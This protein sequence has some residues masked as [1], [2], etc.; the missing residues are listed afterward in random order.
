MA[1]KSLLFEVTN[2]SVIE[3]L[4]SLIATYYVF[5]ISY[6][7]PVPAFSLLLFLQEYL[8]EILDSYAKKSARYK[9]CV[10]R[11]TK[12]EKPKSN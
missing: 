12:L 4:V 10:N 9:A 6:P 1:E 8:M 7:K 5:H 11:L 3:G 2:F